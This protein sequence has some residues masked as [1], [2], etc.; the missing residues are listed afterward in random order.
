MM[1]QIF[2]KA[3][4][5]FRHKD[6][7]F[8]DRYLRGTMIHPE[9]WGARF[10]RKAVASSAAFASGALLE[11]GCGHKPYEDYFRGQVSLY[12]GMDYNAESGYR[13]NRADVYGDVAR[14]P[15]RAEGFS[16]ILCT[17]V[18]E[19][20]PNPHAV[21]AE[22]FC[23]LRPGGVLI[24]TAPF[25]F[26][27]HDEHDYFRYTSKG[28][29]VLLEAGGFEVI[30]QEPL[31]GSGRSLAMMSNIYIH[32][33]CFYWTPWFYPLGVLIRPVIWLVIALINVLGGVVDRLVPSHH[34][35][36]NHLVTARKPL[37]LSRAGQG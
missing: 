26:P 7:V 15:F 37:E 8:T 35:S 17:E 3:V 25:V 4:K 19:H 16:T 31:G 23:G 36:F 22:L 13:G 11:A 5:D 18:L 20:V 9:Y 32:D 28:L 30:S 29:K 2:E 6:R 27:V 12:C 10:I 21:V 24:C 34:L 33:L 14:L 1:K